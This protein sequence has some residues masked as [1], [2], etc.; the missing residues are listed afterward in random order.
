MVKFVCHCHCKCFQLK[1]DVNLK[2]ML[3][4]TN[5]IYGKFIKKNIWIRKCWIQVDFYF[6]ST[7]RDGSVSVKER[8]VKLAASKM[9]PL[10][11]TGLTV[12]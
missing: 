4:I 7:Y 1:T 11:Q 12:L 2:P 8:P 9:L 3:T 5:Q 10:H 6:V